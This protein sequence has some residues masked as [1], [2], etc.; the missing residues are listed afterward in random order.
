M[1]LKGNIPTFFDISEGKVSDIKF[2]DMIEYEAGSYYVMDRGY[3]DYKRL[4]RIHKAGAYFVTRAKVDTSFKRLYSRKVDK[5]AGLRCDQTIRFR[6]RESIKDYPD[7]L[8]RIKYFDA[9]TNQYYVFITN[10]FKVDALTI[11]ILY[12]HRWQVELF[13]KW[14]KQYLK[15]KTFWGHSENAVKTQICIALC[16]YLIVAIIKNGSISTAQFTK[17]YKFLASLFLIKPPF[18]SLFLS[19]HH[20]FKKT[21]INYPYFKG[22]FNRTLVTA[23]MM[24]QMLCRTTLGP[25]LHWRALT[26]SKIAPTTLSA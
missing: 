17:F 9:Q 6:R 20:I 15:I 22:V 11:A 16:A 8:R 2:L 26:A 10:N 23:A 3:I 4:Y 14:I 12:K 7:T 25:F 19:H 5:K 1:D 21:T 18:Y 24:A 13:F